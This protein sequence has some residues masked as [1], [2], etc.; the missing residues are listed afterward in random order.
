M[1]TVISDPDD[2]R[3]A[4]YRHLADPTRRAGFFIVEGWGAVVRLFRTDFAIRSVLVAADKVDRLNVPAG[5]SLLVATQEVVEAT[6]G[7]QLHRG[8]VAAVD[9]RPLVEVENLLG[10]SQ[11]LVVLEGLNDHENLGAILRTVAA[12]GIDGAVLD[13][14]C[15]DP[16]YRRC[17]RVSMGAVLTV[18]IARSSYW[19]EDLGL[20]R[21]HGFKIVA[22]TPDSDAIDIRGTEQFSKVAVM[23]GSEATGLSFD[24]MAAADLRVRIPQSSAMDS[25]NVGHA[26]A[27]ALH[28]F[29]PR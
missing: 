16:F 10:P 23:L 4:D 9:N 28:H 12:L 5:V 24:A 21:E 26:A 3:V 29:A 7:F 22:M 27:I 14:T 6:V 15:A 19:P 11:T 20:L 25:L 1:R 18:P 2:P 17:V 8:V 13:P